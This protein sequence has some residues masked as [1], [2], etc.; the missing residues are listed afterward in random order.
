M[1]SRKQTTCST[2]F[3]HLLGFVH[4][5]KCSKLDLTQLVFVDDLFLLCGADPGSFHLIKEVLADFYLFSGL[6]P[7]LQKTST[8]LACVDNDPKVWLNS[9]LPIPESFLP[10][11]YLGVPLIPTRLKPVDCN[12]F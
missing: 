1:N 12:L 7:N 8:F 5:P 4:H 11:K 2:T 6:Q 9:I 3:I 10:V